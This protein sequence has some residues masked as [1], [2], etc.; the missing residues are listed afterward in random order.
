MFGL[1]EVGGGDEGEVRG[2]TFEWD[3]RRKN[4]RV[5]K[6]LAVG[7]EVKQRE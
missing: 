7:G 5:V 3:D 6:E 1:P 4:W 2:E